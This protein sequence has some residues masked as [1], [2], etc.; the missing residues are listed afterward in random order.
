MRRRSARWCLPALFILLM[1]S[2][3]PLVS[4]VTS[5]STQSNFYDAGASDL[6]TS[7]AQFDQ[8]YLFRFDTTAS[9]HTMTTPSAAD[10][11]AGLSSPYVGE[12][13]FFTVAA[14]GSYTVTISGGMGV[15]VKPSASTVA[16]NTTLAIYWELD[17]VSSGSESVT[18]Y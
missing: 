8:Y 12:V 2:L 13:F 3:L 7:G 17:N 15:T 5:Q 10:I 1:V 18:L 14:D 9:A 16:A 4:C 6:T 11:V